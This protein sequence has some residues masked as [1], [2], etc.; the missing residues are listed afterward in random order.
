V[1]SVLLERFPD[2]KA[3]ILHAEYHR[4]AVQSFGER[5]SRHYSDLAALWKHPAGTAALARLDLLERVAFFKC[6]FFGS[7]WA[8][9]AEAKPGGLR[10]V[11]PPH[12]KGELV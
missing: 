2:A 8:N 11:L 3:T 1:S 6:R 4:L 9:Y 5:F 12:R 7:S 10:L